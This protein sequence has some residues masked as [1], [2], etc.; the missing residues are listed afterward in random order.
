MKKMPAVAATLLVA[1]VLPTLW[2]G[3][4]HAGDR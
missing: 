2:A 1:A 3:A 4:A